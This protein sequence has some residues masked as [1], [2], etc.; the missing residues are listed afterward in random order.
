MSSRTWHTQHDGHPLEVRVQL[1]PGADD[2]VVWIDGFPVHRERLPWRWLPD[3]RI[4]TAVDGTPLVIRLAPTPQGVVFQAI[5][6]GKD[7]ESGR[8]VDLPPARPRL[9]PVEG[10]LPFDPSIYYRCYATWPSRAAASVLSGATM[11]GWAWW[12]TGDTWTEAAQLLGALGCGAF[13]TG[14]WWLLSHHR[15][16]AERFAWGPVAPAIVVGVNPVRIAVLTDLGYDRRCV[17]MAVRVT[18]QP[19]DRVQ[20]V[21]VG[22]RT[23]ALLDPQPCQD[24]RRHPDVHVTA[25]ACGCSDEPTLQA[26]QASFPPTTWDAL[27]EA[28]QA[29]GQPLE[30][31]LH[32]VAPAAPNA[33][34]DTGP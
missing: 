16:T 11:L 12:S 33:A 3:H 31:G 20:R 8:T 14:A 17:A 7:L 9:S 25:A 19:L 34:L 6:G 1:D 10:R 26:L 2:V 5:L 21:T 28:W 27:H 32:W 23:L 4:V 29:V 30:D 24:G 18:T 22:T 13:V 15:A